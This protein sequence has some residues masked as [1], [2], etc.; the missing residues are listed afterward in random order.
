VQQLLHKEVQQLTAL[1]QSLIGAFRLYH[2]QKPDLNQALLTLLDRAAATYQERGRSDREGYVASLKAELITALRGINPITLEKP[3]TRRH[4]M[5][6][7]IAFKVLQSLEAQLRGHLQEAEEP[8]QRAEDL[9]GQILAAGIQNGLITDAEIRDASTQ[10]AIDRLW[11]SISSDADIAFAQK[12]VLLKVSIYDV[13]L[14][15]DK[16]LSNLRGT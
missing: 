9:V 1:Q 11:R 12:R 2:D 6:S 8:L 4:E 10:E 16:L 13:Y 3:A 7:T 14:L 5:Q 15:L